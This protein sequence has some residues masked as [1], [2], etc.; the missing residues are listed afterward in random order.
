MK[1]AGLIKLFGTSLASKEVEELMINSDKLTSEALGL[2]GW[3]RDLIAY[4]IRMADR[5]AKGDI[6]DPPLWPLQ[7]FVLPRHK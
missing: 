3:I 7:P 5:D 2:I 1:G 6:G 4:L